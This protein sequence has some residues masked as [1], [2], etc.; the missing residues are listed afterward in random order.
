MLRVT[1]NRK[2]FAESAVNEIVAKRMNKKR[3][4]RWNRITVQSFLDVHIAV[5]NGK[6]EDAFKHRYPGFRLTIFRW[7]PR[8][9]TSGTTLERAATSSA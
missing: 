3:Q 5:L 7:S 8:G 2:E 1:D 4:M 9:V 6:L